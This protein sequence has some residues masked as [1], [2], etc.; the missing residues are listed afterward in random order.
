MYGHLKFT[1]EALNQTAPNWIALNRTT[2]S[3]T[4]VCI[5]KSSCEICALLRYYAAYGGNSLLT[6]Q[7]NL[8]VPPSID[9]NPKDR[10]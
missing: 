4:K 1:Y 10:S 9:K 6:F 2:Q 3:Q 5:T 8:L 7:D